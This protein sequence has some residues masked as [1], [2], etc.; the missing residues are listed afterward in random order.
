MRHLGILR[1]NKP[2]E[3]A[4][5]R[6][7]PI[8]CDWNILTWPLPH[9]LP[10]AAQVVSTPS[11]SRP[12]NSWWTRRSQGWL[13]LGSGSAAL[14]IRWSSWMPTPSLVAAHEPAISAAALTADGQRRWVS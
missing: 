2:L 4:G 6:V 3:P 11:H 10:A 9:P 14:R 8:V 7:E 5:G 12:L 1:P 13:R